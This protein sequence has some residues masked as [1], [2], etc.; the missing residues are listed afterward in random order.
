VPS[1]PE[2]VTDLSSGAQMRRTGPPDGPA[3]LCLDGG[4][5]LPLRGDWSASIRYLVRRLAPMHPGLGFVEV[6]YRI[7]SWRRLG[8]CIEDGRAALTALTRG[9]SR[10]VLLLGYSMG[11]A[12]AIAVAGDPAVTTVLG[13]APWIPDELDV[14]SLA[15][16]RVSVIHGTVDGRPGGV[17][18]RN[19]RR[20]VERIRGL[21]IDADYRLLPGATHAIALAAPGGRLVP[22]P[23]ARAWAGLVDEELRRFAAGA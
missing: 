14:A 12:V 7:R 15:G 3:V 17:S 21:G 6:R 20:A 8:M 19:S 4:V 11:G 2:G 9:A 5:S 13:L 22:L 10:P 1:G 23:R 18:P 16:R